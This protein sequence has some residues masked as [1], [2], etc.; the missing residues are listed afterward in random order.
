MYNSF[1]EVSQMDFNKIIEKIK[2]LDS[3]GR[4]SLIRWALVA[5][6]IIMILP[7]ELVGGVALVVFALLFWGSIIAFLTLS[8]IIMVQKKRAKK[9]KS[10]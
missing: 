4:L 5:F 2:N 3:I 10:Y 7:C 8:V 9:G 6:A 1:Y